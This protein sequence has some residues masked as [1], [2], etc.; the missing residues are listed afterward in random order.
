MTN[1]DWEI[2]KRV[3]RLGTELEII[4]KTLESV[5]RDYIVLRQIVDKSQEEQNEQEEV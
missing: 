4:E 1:T 3:Y 2:V 5:K